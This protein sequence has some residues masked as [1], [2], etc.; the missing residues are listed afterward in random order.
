M[1]SRSLRRAAALLLALTLIC[2]LLTLPAAADDPATGAPA[3]GDPVNP[4]PSEPVLPTGISLSPDSLSLEV[5][6]TEQLTATLV[7]D[8]SE[9]T[10]TWLSS[11][12]DVATVD[13]KGNVKAIA[14][15]DIQITARVKDTPLYA[16]CRVK[17]TEVNVPVTGIKLNEHTLEKMEGD[18]SERLTA[19]ITPENATDKSI[20]FVSNDPSVVKVDSYGNLTFLKEGTAQITATANGGNGLSDWCVINVKARPPVIGVTLNK[21]SLNLLPGG[22]ETLKATVEGA[23]A[24]QGVNWFSSSPALVKVN[25]TTGKVDVPSTTK[26]GTQVTITARAVADPTKDALCVVTVVEPRL[27]SVQSVEITT[28]STDDKFRYV[29]PGKTIILTAVATPAEAPAAD[30]VITWSS[31]DTSVATVSSVDS[32]NGKVT[33]RAPGVATITAKAAGGNAPPATREIEVSGILLSYIKKSTTGGQGETISLTERSVV[34]IYQ[35]R[36]ISVA[37]KAFGNAKN[38]TIN[39]ESSNSSVAQVVGGRVTANYPGEAVITAN[40]AGESYSASFKVKVSEDVADAITVN[41]GSSPSYSF[42]NILSLLNSRSQSKAGAPLDNVYS[43]NVS[44]ENGVLYYKYISPETPGHGVGGTER[45]YYQPM[46]QGQMALRD[47]TFVPLPG[48]DGTAVVEYNAVATNNSTFSGTIRIEATATGDVT[49]TTT[50]NKPVDFASEHFSAICK[51][52][53]GRAISYVTFSLPS[54]SRGTLY[55]NYVTSGQFAQKVTGNTRYY[56]T[57]KPSID[58]I[59]FVPAEGYIGS[60]GIPYR[61]VDSAGASFTGTIT[62]RVYGTGGSSGGGSGTSGGSDVVYSIGLNQWQD[63]SSTDFNNACRWATGSNL[64]Y[65]RFSSL[66]SSGAGTLYLNYANSDSTRVSSNRNYYR[67]SW[68][69]ISSITFVPSRNYSGTVSI[70]F[71]GTNV[72]GAAF[73]GDLVIH[74]ANGTSSGRQIIFYSTVTDGYVHLNASDFNSACRSATG[75]PLNY[76]RFTNLPSSIYGKLYHQYNGYNRTGDS[77]SS[78]TAY[79]YSGSGRRLINDV[80]FAAASTVGTAT[81]GYTGYNTQGN[82]FTGTVEVTVTRPGSVSGVPSG[83]VS[84]IIPGVVS[85]VS[86]SPVRYIGSSAAPITFRSS[87]FQNACLMTLGSGLSY[88][89]FNALPT[90]GRVYQNFSTSWT[91]IGLTTTTHYSLQDLDQLSYIPAAGSQETIAIPYTACS[92][93]GTFHSGT[94]EIQLSNNYCYASFSDTVSGWDWAKPSIEFLRHCG[95]TNGYSNNTYRPGQSISRGEFTLM[96]CRAFRFPTTVTNG[97]SSFSDVPS[98]SSYAGAVATAE[99]LGIIQGDNGRFRPNQPI[100]RQ[101]AMTMICRA[102]EASGQSLP[103]A[104]TNLLSSYTDGGQVSSFARSSVAT[105]VEM[106]A[107]QGNSSMRLNPGAAISRAEMAVILHRVLTY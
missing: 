77:V 94:V 40:V 24:S 49:Y 92:V 51:G 73:S 102:I 96:L 78:S 106:G 65:I 14:K 58:D 34:D 91:T 39:W 74:V 12:D 63:L 22:S 61:C 69:Y 88:V 62:V 95:I 81:F 8:G 6:E 3:T 79:Y 5:G 87:D 103:A 85:S 44:T 84:G 31:S 25:E 90:K 43:L 107:V 32:S 57:S 101:S 13:D 35:Y 4:T 10:V 45:Y 67:N 83:V 60:V 105:L 93:Q 64:N 100:T 42:S 53:S 80:S 75:Y 18:P 46:G 70:P 23:A 89:Q 30:R 48:F 41:M 104:D 38:K 11:N 20:S 76:I 21:T 16:Q 15:G 82:S 66:P 28:S 59:T 98:S 19:T 1:K 47:V 37:V 27:P 36:D 68:P 99:D 86:S 33:G 7:P 52:R 56:A 17:V 72:S 50:M 2:S 9:G 97:F 55:Y 26:P 29:D 54:A 71:T